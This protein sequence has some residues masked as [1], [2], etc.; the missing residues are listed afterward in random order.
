M[1]FVETKLQG[2]LVLEPEAFEDERGSFARLFDAEEFA[3]RGLD[4]RI[5]Q[6]STSSNRRTGTLR[7]LH[8]Q[9]APH[10][11]VKLVR[12]TQGAVYDVVADLRPESA[13]YLQWFAV[14]LTAESRKQV[15]VPMGC[16]HGFQTLVDDSEV[17][18]Q[19]SEPF[20]P[21]S[22][23]GARWDDPALGIA[24]PPSSTRTIS[25]KDRAYTDL[26]P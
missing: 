15:Y 11:E 22:Y 5:S 17:E 1:R 24:W 25:D 9:H 2:V 20:A 7:G 19:M 23:A 18:Y 6:R 16:A 13:T 14:E 8:F 4:A 10:A 26:R 12:C 21:G 3:R